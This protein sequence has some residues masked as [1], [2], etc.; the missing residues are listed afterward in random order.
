L[1][2]FRL[3]LQL[4][5]PHPD[6]LIKQLSCSQFNEWMLYYQ[7]EPWGEYRDELR[8]G[9]LCALIHNANFTNRVKT[10]DYMDYVDRP[11]EKP[12]T[13]EETIAQI[14]KEVFGL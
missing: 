6:Y 13:P 14:D 8:N 11:E 1:F 7:A 5:L 10:I 4:G 2:A 12:M 9:K 3:C